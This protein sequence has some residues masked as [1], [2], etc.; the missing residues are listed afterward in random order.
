[1]S[2]STDEEI[3][4]LEEKLED[5]AALWRGTRSEEAVQEYHETMKR[6]YELGWNERLIIQSLLPVDIMPKEYIKRNGTY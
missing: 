3:G 1:M 2:D 4:L 5:L 6:L